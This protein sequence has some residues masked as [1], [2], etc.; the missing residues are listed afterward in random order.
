ME[1]YTKDTKNFKVGNISL[2]EGRTESIEYP[3]G[4]EEGEYGKEQKVGDHMENK[5]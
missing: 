4:C 3:K 2:G 1:Q 5:D